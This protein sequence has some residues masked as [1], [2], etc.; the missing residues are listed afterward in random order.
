MTRMPGPVRTV[1][2][3]LLLVGTLP[4]AASALAAAKVANGGGGVRITAVAV[5]WLVVAGGAV[6]A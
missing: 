6:G 2:V 4:A 5:G 3:L 1:R